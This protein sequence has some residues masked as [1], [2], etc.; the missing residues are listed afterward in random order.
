M[1][2]M[3]EMG[4]SMPP[5]DFNFGVIFFGLLIGTLIVT[6]ISFFIGA[7]VQFLGARIF[8]GSGD[9]KSHLYLLAVIQVPVT[10]LGGVTSIIA[11][12]PFIAFVASL[13]GFALSIFTL[14]VTVR[15][16]KAVH[17]LPTGR[18]IAGMILFPIILVV[19]IGCL[20]IIF[21]S[22]LAGIVGGMG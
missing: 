6:P 2:E 20:L 18:A 12:V 8:G 1:V 22:A 15:A 16:I 10:I 14:I 4:E 13:A 3:A 5:L 11:L 9:F 17:S 7:G 19:V 21:G